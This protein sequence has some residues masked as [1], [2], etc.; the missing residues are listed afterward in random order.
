MRRDDL[1]ALTDGPSTLEEALRVPDLDDRATV[2][3]LWDD[4]A[5]EA[6]VIER[7]AAPPP[8]APAAVPTP[9]VAEPEAVPERTSRR[10]ARRARRDRKHELRLEKLKRRRHRILPRTVLGIASMLLFFGLGVGVAGAA[11]YAYYDWR[12]SENEARVGELSASL[13]RRL[14]AANQ[15][16]D[17][18]ASAAVDEIR[19]EMGPFREL[20][21]RQRIAN[22]LVGRLDGSVWFVETLDENGGPSVGSAFVA[23][24]DD[25]QSLL[26]TSY[27][28]VAAGTTE[29][30]PTIT[31]R[32]GDESFEA[33][34]YNWD[35]DH[36]LAL[37]ILPR[38]GLEPLEWADN[39][40]MS[41]LVGTHVWAAEG[42][43]GN[44]VSLSPGSVIDQSDVGIQHTSPLNA[45]FRGGPIVNGQGQVVGISSTSYVPLNFPS[46]AV[47]FGIPVQAT[48][49]RILNCDGDVRGEGEGA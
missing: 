42:L 33:D 32:S 21:D 49:E 9:V 29:P 23:A 31:V 16:L 26:V 18:A 22:N 13:E 28:A 40:T 8:A 47:S 11:L 1:G 48:C 12:L 45:A 19:G 17:D 4:L 43:G 39:Q 46:G 44:G 14:E 25:A 30:A 34:L 3:G 5:G 6:P 35:P 36:D 37:L 15:G 24:S 41:Q 2:R 7:P 10:E 20:M 27:S 38:G